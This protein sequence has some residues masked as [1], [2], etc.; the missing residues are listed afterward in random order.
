MFKRL[1]DEEIL[2]KNGWVM[3]CCSPLEITDNEGS[4]AQ[5]QAARI[6]IESFHREYYEEQKEAFLK[7]TKNLIHQF[8]VGDIDDEE[9]K[10]AANSLMDIDDGY[11]F[12]LDGK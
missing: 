10:N 5:N 4:F 3:E 8:E 7:S 6:V 9:F 12:T 11:T 1:S 2:D